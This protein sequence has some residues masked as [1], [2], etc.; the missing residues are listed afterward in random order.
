MLKFCYVP[1]VAP[2]VIGFFSFFFAAALN[3]TN[4]ANK[5]GGMHH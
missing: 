2:L 1:L 5:A 3:N 4:E